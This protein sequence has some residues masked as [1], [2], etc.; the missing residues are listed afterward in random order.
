MGSISSQPIQTVN[1]AHKLD[2]I[3]EQWKPRIVGELNESYVKLARIQGEFVW[4]HHSHEDELFWVLKG[5]LVIKLRTG[6]LEVDEGEFVIIPRGVE[7]CPY[8]ADEVHIMLLEPKSTINTGNVQ[9]DRTAAS[10]WI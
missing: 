5:R 2:L 1:A 3:K 9:S 8:A 7:H 6:D 10:E 4:H